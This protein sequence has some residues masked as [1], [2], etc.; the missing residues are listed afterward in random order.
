MSE[1]LDALYRLIDPKVDLERYQERVKTFSLKD[2]EER[3]NWLKDQPEQNQSTRDGIKRLESSMLSRQL[4]DKVE[5]YR[6]KMKSN[7]EQFLPR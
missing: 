6:K 4:Q 7:P 2:L 3:I 5:F 1:R